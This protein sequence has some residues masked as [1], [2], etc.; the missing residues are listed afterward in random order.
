MKK[1]LTV[2]LAL[3][4]VFTYTV[5]TAFAADVPT[6]D[7][8]NA[9]KAKISEEQKL[10]EAAKISAVRTL[11]ATPVPSGQ[12]A[13][14]DVKYVAVGNYWFTVADI[15]K[16]AALVVEESN[17]VLEDKGDLVLKDSYADT[18]A[19]NTALAIIDAS[20]Y[21]NGTDFANEITNLDK[22][23]DLELE[24]AKERYTA[25]VNAVN[26]SDYSAEKDDNGISNQDRVSEAQTIALEGI[27]AATDP[28]DGANNARS[29]ANAFLTTIDGIAT[30]VDE[31][32]AAS[33]LATAK[34]IA[35]SLM[36]AAYTNTKAGL[37]ADE[38]A[39]IRAAEKVSPQ[40]DATKK[41][42]ADAKERIEILEAKYSAAIELLKDQIN[43]LSSIN[44]KVYGAD[45]NGWVIGTI[46]NGRYTPKAELT[47][48]DEQYLALAVDKKNQIDDL[49]E[50]AKLAKEFIGIEGS[51]YFSEEDVDT[52]LEAAIEKVYQATS[53]AAVKAITLD[54][55]T[56]AEALA[57]RIKALIGTDGKVTVVVNKNAYP[58]VN[59]WAQS[60]KDPATA[61]TSFTYDSAVQ[62]AVADL[63]AET[64]AALKEATSIA[65]AE[66]I[67]LDA[68]EKYDAYVTDKEH[69]KLYAKGGAL[70]EA[71]TS[72]EKQIEAAIAA[73]KVVTAGDSDYSFDVN[74][75]F[76]SNLITEMKKANTKEE[77]DSKFNEAK[78]IVENVKTVSAIKAEAKALN[79]KATAISAPIDATKK[80]EVVAIL[81]GYAELEDYIKTI[82]T[83]TSPVM[84]KSLVT[85]Y[86][87]TIADAEAKAIN[88]AIKAV[89]KVTVDDKEAIEKIREDFDAYVDLVDKYVLTAATTPTETAVS[90][91]ETALSEAQVDEVTTLIMN[92]DTVVNSGN[93]DQVRAA[94]AAYDALNAAQKAS[95]SKIVYDKMIAVGKLA[96]KFEVTSVEALKITASSSA[97]KGS[98]TVKW[99]VKGDSSAADGFQVYRSLKMNSGF[100]TKAFFT[101]TDNT[102]RTYKNTKSLK[103]GTRYYYKIRAYK[104]VDGVKY[105]SD[106]SNK[107]Y[108]IAK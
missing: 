54:A 41:T 74:S 50:E 108:R 39:K 79:D 77:L 55:M 101:T 95:I 58:T 87:Q 26:L 60:A 11:T 43:A 92:L 100:G 37:I 38:N 84:Y 4:V 30:V 106:W 19:L 14:E 76:A 9:V 2:L 3:S 56:P 24:Y 88:D 93:I 25:L 23:A 32:Y 91:L 82:D 36:T 29:F 5:G 107:A 67:F 69:N 75:K 15:D 90:N 66:K 85:S 72:Y 86:L 13:D 35:I 27:A 94:Q 78:S 48:A 64:K 8:H 52:A 51:K 7:V 62:T 10:V 59:A 20:G 102:K 70:Y 45:G 53:V 12:P 17:K 42:I 89:G 33:D 71:A 99:T 49:N 44:D 16:L 31:S 1:F 105:Y 80:A 6:L 68:Y 40:T 98:I 104:V 47:I 103:K 65:E 96:D 97:V 46:T 63:A 34:E 61:A 73:K 81:D 57:A 83:A 21:K 22:I 18:D 28:F